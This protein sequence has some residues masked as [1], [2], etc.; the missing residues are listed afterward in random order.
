MK[1]LHSNTDPWKDLLKD[2][3]SQ[4][5]ADNQPDWATFSKR[6]HTP[7][8]G[9]SSVLNSNRVVLGLSLFAAII[10]ITYFSFFYSE[11]SVVDDDPKLGTT[12]AT[13]IEKDNQLPSSQVEAIKDTQPEIKGEQIQSPDNE[14]LASENKTISSEL[15]VEL[16][17]YENSDVNDKMNLNPNDQKEA[18]QTNKTNSSL[19]FVPDARF[20]YTVNQAC[21]PMVVNCLPN[22]LNDSVFY[23]WT[24]SE[25]QISTESKCS[26]TF[27]KPGDHW[28]TLTVNYFQ[29]VEKASYT[30]EEGLYVYPHPSS[31][32]IVENQRHKYEFR[33]RFGS[34]SEYNWEIADLDFNNTRDLEY[35]FVKSG[36][37]PVIL[38]IRT[39]EG[40]YS[41]TR[42]DIKVEVL[43]PVF[44]GNAFTP[45]GDGINDY[46]GP[47]SEAIDE[48]DY[49]MEIY[50]RYG[51]IIF[52][53]NSADVLWDGSIFGNEPA[54][55]GF[56]HYKITT[57]DQLG[58]SQTKT[59]EVYLIRKK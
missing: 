47:K 38:K 6:L 41:E 43:H 56:Y 15:Q 51:S 7:A 21:S 9:T 28:I 53:T 1:D 36:T 11:E 37:Y 50:N 14:I 42:K 2:K 57:R 20:S 31:D 29:T 44:V 34:Y 10:A 12:I 25:G 45:D 35:S 54:S 27:T 55:E 17:K 3:V 59:G 5:S 48:Y 40:C 8:S 18:I 13:T 46:F 4:Y 19:P 22:E 24:S 26:F 30:Q 33:P 39:S 16:P 58:N 49:Q 32:F 52:R 23:L